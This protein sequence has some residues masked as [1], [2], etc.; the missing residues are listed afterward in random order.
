MYGARKGGM[1]RRLGIVEGEERSVGLGG[2]LETLTGIDMDIDLCIA[3]T[4]QSLL[5][6]N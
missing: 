1:G 2:W 6:R 3:I 4:N 5:H